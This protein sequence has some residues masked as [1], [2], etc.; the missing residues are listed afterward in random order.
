MALPP[1]PP[2]GQPSYSSS[3][4]TIG[5][6]H[7]TGIN[8]VHGDVNIYNN[9]PSLASQ[10]K[11]AELP[12]LP[13]FARIFLSYKRGS[14]PDEA[15]AL[16]IY[17]ALQQ[18]HQVF[19]DQAMSVGTPWVERIKQEIFQ[20]DV[21]IV[22]LSAQSVQS[23][24]L[25]KEIELANEAAGQRGG[26]PLIFPVRLAYHAPFRYPLNQHLDP[27][28]W[29]IWEQAADT[30]RLIAE[31]KS[32]LAGEP[33]PINT[34]AAKQKLLE[35]PDPTAL[36]P[37][38]AMAQPPVEQTPLAIPL[39]LPEGT[40][41]AESP[42]Y[43]QRAEEPKVLDAVQRRG[44]TITILGPRQMGKS[45][46]LIRAMT[47]ARQHEKKIVFLDFQRLETAALTNAD[48]FYR[49]FCELLTLRLR[50]PSQ[51]ED[52]WQQYQAL[53]NPDRCSSYIQDYLLA[54]LNH[55]VFLAMDEVDKLIA[56]PFRDEFFGMLRTWHNERA[57]E[58][59]WKRLD[60]VMVTC[61][62]PYQLIQ[63]LNQS[64]FNVG[65]P[66]YLNDF[67]PAEVAELNRRHGGVLSAA[68]LERLMDWVGG[69]PY[70][71]R[72]ALY[73]IASSEMTLDA[74]LK[75]AKLDRGP[76]SGH[77]RYH[78]FRMQDKPHLVRGLLQVIR[79]QTC[80]DE[81]VLR[82]LEA[83]GLV[84]QLAASRQVVPRCRLYAE[85]F[86]EHLRE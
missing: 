12:E 67:R 72:K 83:A 16:D 44:C 8:T 35:S 86:R 52:W 69:H 20:A 56:S 65:T 38:D 46:L 42:F 78:F 53:G 60:L 27:I 14:K 40:M 9:A 17:E 55:A 33:L 7:G 58:P 63:D 76:F 34:A 45:S 32:A 64:P 66:V 73:L 81:Q 82:R 41:E 3:E 5:K 62:E 48:L 54:E 70:L 79:N 85:Y 25:Q 84:K 4:Q 49:R 71:V 26:L 15:V 19:I 61:T 36:T 74:V 11:K 57:F 37:P 77:L 6:N 24:M 59:T 13:D 50:L 51:V 18:T 80:R 31:I 30:P 47:T 75:T 39:E 68:A 29:A 2:G 43:I 21:L 22:L 23:E 28:Q 1:A 10:G